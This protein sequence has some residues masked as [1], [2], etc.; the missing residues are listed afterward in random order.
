VNKKKMPKYG[1][2]FVPDVPKAPKVTSEKSGAKEPSEVFLE[3]EKLKDEIARRNRDNDDTLS[4]LN[5]ENFSPPIRELLQ[6]VLKGD[7]SNGGSE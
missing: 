2:V 7:G 5:L 6:K 4:N 3:L 1:A